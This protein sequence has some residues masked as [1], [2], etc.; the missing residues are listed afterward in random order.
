MA[1]FSCFLA[2]TGC[3][4]GALNKSQNETLSLS[5]PI[6]LDFGVIDAHVHTKF[7]DKPEPNSGIIY[8][9][10]QLIQEMRGAGVVAA[11]SMGFNHRIPQT[12]LN[13]SGVFL[14]AGIRADYNLRQL[15]SQIKADQY[16]CLKIYLGYVHLFAKDPIYQPIYRLAAKYKLPVVFHTG[17]IYDQDGLLKY[18]D[19]LTID[20]VAVQHRDVNFVIA[21]MGNPWVQSAAEVAYKNPNVFL[22]G[23]AFFA[24]PLQNYAP[25]RIQNQMIASIKWVFD[26]VENPKKILFGTDWP[27]VP[28]R[29][30]L[31]AFQRA[32]PEKHWREVFRENAI[33]IYKLPEVPAYPERPKR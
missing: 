29:E 9:Q 31:A 1:W 16:K 11:V 19:P 32:I 2:V 26:Y 4:H 12:D 21:H 8:N 33:R 3:A 22:E 15:E 5:E 10:Q 14:C 28:I 27:L 20:E 6:P 24:G 30:Y 23:S 13:S 25:E 18:S 17:D 7:N